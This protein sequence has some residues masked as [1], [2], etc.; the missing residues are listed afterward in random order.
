MTAPRVAGFENTTGTLR[1]FTSTDPLVANLANDIEAL[2][3]GHVV[4]VNRTIRDARGMRVTD[5]DIELQNSIIQVKSGA[6]GRLPGQM[7]RT[8]NAMGVPVIG[9]GP[10]LARGLV[11]H[12]EMQGGLVTT[13]RQLLL[14]VVKP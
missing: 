3:P 9:Y 14:E 10:D 2:Y 8:E 4:S 6:G 12:I 5:L 1:R 7:I 11:R 13:D